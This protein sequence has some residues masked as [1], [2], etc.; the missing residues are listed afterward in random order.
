MQFGNNRMDWESMN[1][2]GFASL[3]NE[4]YTGGVASST[5]IARE[6]LLS[7]GLNEPI[8]TDGSFTG[9]N[10][11][12]TVDMT[13]GCVDLDDNGTEV[14]VR[15]QDFAVSSSARLVQHGDSGGPVFAHDDGFVSPGVGVISGGNVGT[16]TTPGPGDEVNFTDGDSICNVSGECVG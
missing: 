13:E 2:E 6:S 15:D 1:T 9:E 8:C 7:A 16:D 12:G 5:G 3:A 11:N 4:V 10:C 14:L